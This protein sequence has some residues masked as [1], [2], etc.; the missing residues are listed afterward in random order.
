VRRA[1]RQVVDT[2]GAGDTFA[3]YYAAARAVGVGF[4]DALGVATAAAAICVS[5]PGAM[6]SV[7]AGDD[8]DGW[9]KHV[10]PRLYMQA[11][12]PLVTPAS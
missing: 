1:A 6:A 2:T 8:V 11:P 7:P 4:E 3:G 9:R 12:P 10:A 5:R